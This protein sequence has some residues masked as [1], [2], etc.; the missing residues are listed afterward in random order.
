MPIIYDV[1]RRRED[2]SEMKI[3]VTGATGFI[4]GHLVKALI[5]EQHDVTCL[6]RNEEKGKAL[7][8]RFH[9][10]YVIGDVTN[11]DSLNGLEKDYEVIFHLAAIGHV[12]AASDDAL[13]NFICVNE[14]GTSNLINYFKDS[15]TL[16]K[17]IHFSSTAAMGPIGIPYLDENSVPNPITPYQI[18]KNRSEKISLNAY[19]KFQFPTVVIRPCMV[20]GVGGYGEFYKFC[21]LM[22]R[23]VFPKVGFGKNLTPLVN[24]QDVVQASIE[25]MYRGKCGESYIIASEESL[26]M[27]DL[28]ALIMKNIGKRG[29]Y[30]FVPTFIALLGA[31]MLE[32][33]S[34]VLNKE[35]IVTYRNIKSTITDRTFLI[36]KAKQE[37][38]YCPKVSFEE[39]IAETI[40]WYKEEGKL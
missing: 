31:K 26:S 22:N 40:A 6:V 13:K 30:P 15:K 11:K 27:D 19:L 28:H 36:D 8:N 14:E 23:G 3:L 4:G 25:V 24:V 16:K 34:T 5:K 1:D 37:L 21:R 32:I 2:Q 35:P 20:Y 29:R 7:Q 39:G 12:S 17:F 10:R 9:V 33:V 38:G 18:S